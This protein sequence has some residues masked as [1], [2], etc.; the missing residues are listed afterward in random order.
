MVDFFHKEDTNIHG[1]LGLHLQCTLT[2]IC[3]R[4]HV[5]IKQ[6]GELCN[7]VIAL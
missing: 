7:A 2:I 3:A 4:A 6:R 5:E 1:L